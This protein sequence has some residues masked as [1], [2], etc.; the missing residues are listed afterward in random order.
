[1][2]A[3]I[4]P[5]CYFRQILL[6]VLRYFSFN[7]NRVCCTLVNEPSFE[8]FDLLTIIVMAVTVKNEIL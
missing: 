6:S 4:R 8:N 7:T 2:I 1:M 3:M 5:V